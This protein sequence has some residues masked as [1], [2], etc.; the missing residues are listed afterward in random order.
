MDQMFVWEIASHFIEYIIE[1]MKLSEVP[2]KSYSS[3]PLLKV[4]LSC[5]RECRG[6]ETQLI[7]QTSS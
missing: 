4:E 5:F 6:I 1:F 3:T 2:E 7:M